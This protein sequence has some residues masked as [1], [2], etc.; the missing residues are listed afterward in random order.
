MV[1]E[2]YLYPLTVQCAPP[3]FLAGQAQIAL[4]SEPGSLSFSGDRA[5]RRNELRPGWRPAAQRIGQVG[6]AF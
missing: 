3:R 4:Q 1:G 6:E 2:T 5:T